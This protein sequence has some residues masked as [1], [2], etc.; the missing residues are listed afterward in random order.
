LTPLQIALTGFA[1]FVVVGLIV[2]VVIGRWM[3]RSGTPP[4]RDSN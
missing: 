1:A 4:A 3:I 2:K